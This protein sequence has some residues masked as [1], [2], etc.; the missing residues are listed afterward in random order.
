[1][2]RRRV[3]VIRIDEDNRIY[4]YSRKV[5]YKMRKNG[6]WVV[7]FVG[8]TLSSVLESSVA[9]DCVKKKLE[10]ILKNLNHFLIGV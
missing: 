5:V 8:L 4:V 1:M 10:K 6:K 9:N 3:E 7:K 2:R